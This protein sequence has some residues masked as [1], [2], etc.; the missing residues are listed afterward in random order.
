MSVRVQY[1]PY[2]DFGRNVNH[3]PRSRAYPV[4]AAEPLRSVMHDRRVPIFDQGELGSCTGNAGIGC[5][6]TEPFYATVKDKTPDPTAR[7]TEQLTLTQEG[8]VALY[9]QAT[10][11]DGFYGTYPPTDTGSD[12][13]SIAK[14]L[15]AVGWISGYEHAFNIEQFLSGLM[16]RPCIVGTEWTVGMGQ[17]DA[18]GVVR[19]TGGVQGGHEYQAIGYDHAAGLVWFVNSWG[20]G[21][22]KGGFFA[23]DVTDFAGLL[24]RQGDA[25]FF[26]PLSASAPEPVADPDDVLAAALRPWATRAPTS[27][28]E[29]RAVRAWLKAK[30]LES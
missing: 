9:A 18:R 2:P 17:P 21:W 26:T 1:P 20:A 16:T 29:K 12:G 25:T 23:M 22:A 19:P 15:H 11:L 5:M 10:A 27:T 8:A 28:A 6:G 7:W 4:R 30:G 13:L 3:D 24:S 14:A